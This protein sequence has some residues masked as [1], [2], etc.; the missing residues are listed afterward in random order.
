MTATTANEK[1]VELWDGFNVKF[2][3][4]LLDDFDFT[5][6]LSDAI[7]NNDL[8]AMVEMYMATIG[9]ENV[10]QQIREHIEQKEG[11]F[12]QKSLIGVLQKI[13]AAFPKAGNRA[14]RRSWKTS[15]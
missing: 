5:S 12:S 2:N 9:G 1:T 15:I 10:Y 6:D 11:Y 13:D 4:Q 8:A 14:Q 3:E 7:Q